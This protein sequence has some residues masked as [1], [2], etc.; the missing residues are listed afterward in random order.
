M[1]K[2]YGKLVRDKIPEIIEKEGKACHIH[3]ADKEEY[4]SAISAKL[5][6]E[7]SELSAAK[8]KEEKIRE[9]ADVLEVLETI[10]REEG[11]SREE[12]LKAQTEKR[13]S[14]GG[15]SKKIILEEVSD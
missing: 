12:V 11:I 3:I 10:W 5:I 15:F 14:N 7:S 2:K 6:E 8:T 9:S 4:D 1:N 13:E